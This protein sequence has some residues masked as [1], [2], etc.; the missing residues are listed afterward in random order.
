MIVASIKLAVVIYLDAQ[1]FCPAHLCTCFV[2]P[3]QVDRERAC[4]ADLSRQLFSLD[5]SV[6][7]QSNRLFGL[8]H[9]H[10]LRFGNH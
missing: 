6:D 2:C 10:G 4:E 1:K 5:G 9:N 3:Q 7:D 8:R